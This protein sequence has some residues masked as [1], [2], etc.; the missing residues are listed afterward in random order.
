MTETSGQPMVTVCVPVW[1]GAGFVAETLSAILHQSHR[2]LRVL[3]SVDRSDDD[4]LGAC[5]RFESDLRV[6]VLARRERLGWVAN[7]NS[8]LG[9]I[10]T[11]YFCVIPHDDLI[12]ERYVETLLEA[13]QGNPRAACS[14]AD[15]ETFGGWTARLA[16]PGLAGP[17]L[18]RVMTFLCA[19]MSAVGMRG[20]IARKRLGAQIRVRHGAAYDFAAD[21]TWM[22]ELARA[23]ELQRIPSVLYRKR[24]HA[25]SQTIRWARRGREEVLAGW[26]EHCAQCASIALEAAEDA[27][28]R[29][30][31]MLAAR[32]RLR[33]EVERFNW[34]IDTASLVEPALGAM[35]AR[36]HERSGIPLALPGI[37]ALAHRPEMALLVA[38]C[39]PDLE[40]LARIPP[41]ARSVLELASAEASLGDAYLRRAPDAQWHR[42]EPYEFELNAAAP[43]PRA[44]SVDALVLGQALSRL[45][46]PRQALERL[47]PLLRE[48]GVAI[49]CLPGADPRYASLRVAGLVPI[50]AVP[51]NTLHAMHGS[52]VVRAARR[53]V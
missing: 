52:H 2:A 45:H 13:L 3:V 14:F 34:A 42:L 27:E 7:I 40:V 39:A 5:R 28:E 21:T 50:D 26:I 11:D 10:E 36:F 51:Y 1:N 49:A 16:Q 44:G 32:A 23:G 17:R 35:T 46:D 24:V 25:G 33:Q 15:I 6:R 19:H 29:G 30:M 20:L 9:G 22:L 53:R 41:G 47:A 43:A 38:A 8:L 4:S 31:I 12:D 18:Q 48:G 37:S